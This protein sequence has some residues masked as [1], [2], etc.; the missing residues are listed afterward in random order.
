MI[1]E[2]DIG[3]E[4]I[5]ERFRH[6]IV[7]DLKARW[8]RVPSHDQ[9]TMHGSDFEGDAWFHTETGEMR[10]TVVLRCSRSS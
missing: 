10:W 8:V 2:N 5:A 7:T 9:R 6:H 4:H 1:H 3:S